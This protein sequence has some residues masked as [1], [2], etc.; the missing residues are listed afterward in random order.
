MKLQKKSIAAM[1]FA[2]CS[3]QLSFGQAF[4]NL[5][6]ET[7][8]INNLATANLK[9]DISSV[10]VI[11]YYAQEE[12]GQ[13][14]KGNES[15]SDLYNYD[16]DGRLTFHNESIEYNDKGL[17]SQT[18]LWRYGKDVSKTV[19]EYDA[20]NKCVGKKT[21]DPSNVLLS[22]SKCV[23]DAQGN[24]IREM[25]TT[26]DAKANNIKNYTYVNAYTYSPEG[27]RTSYANK[28]KSGA[29]FMS[30]TYELDDK[31]NPKKEIMWDEMA[32]ESTLTFKYTKF[33]E[34]GNWI[35]CIADRGYGNIKLICR[36]ITYVV[37]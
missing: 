35:E 31:G 16:A 14:V 27:I 10:K 30:Y 7:N 29:V 4:T 25:C 33:D 23:T 8:P 15:Q 32:G 12:N 34:K 26:T 22:T 28:E 6:E 36:E 5:Y 9:G 19:F 13:I 3:I 17:V 24:I 20:N 2:M 11:S 37:E 21:Y 1:L 18:S